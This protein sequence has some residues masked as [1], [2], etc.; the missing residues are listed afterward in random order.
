VANL[1]SNPGFET[2]TTGYDTS[3]SAFTNS[4]ATLTR[5]TSDF[6]AGTACASVAYTNDANQKGIN[7]RSMALVANTTYRCSAWVRWKSGRPVRLRLRDWNNGTSLFYASGFTSTDAWVELSFI[8]TAGP[9]AA[10]HA[11]NV[12]SIVTD[13]TTGTGTFYCDEIILDTYPTQQSCGM[14]VG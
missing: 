1:F 8:F 4:G 5:I 6:Q 3:S 2:N 7:A 12:F 11:N 9:S 13:T 14:L 10:T